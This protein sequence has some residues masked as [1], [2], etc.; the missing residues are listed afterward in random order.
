MNLVFGGKLKPVI[1][2]VVPLG[3]GVEAIQVLARGEQF[4]K[5]VLTP[6]PDEG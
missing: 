4:G 3:Q 5:I 6:Y 2:R 1:D